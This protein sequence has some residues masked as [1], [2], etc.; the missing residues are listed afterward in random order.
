MEVQF[1]LDDSPTSLVSPDYFSSEEEEMEV[2][3]HSVSTEAT[4]RH[5]LIMT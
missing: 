4:G 3:I 2:D 1:V 5:W